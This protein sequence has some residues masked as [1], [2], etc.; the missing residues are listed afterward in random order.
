MSTDDLK[1]EIKRQWALITLNEVNE[2]IFGKPRG[3]DRGRGY[4]KARTA[5]LGS[6]SSTKSG[7]ELVWLGTRSGAREMS[8]IAPS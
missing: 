6:A 2:C 4:Q 1:A 3:P 5:I 8:V 7:G